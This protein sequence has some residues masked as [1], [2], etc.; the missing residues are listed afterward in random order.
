MYFYHLLIFLK[1]S[2]VRAAGL[3]LALVSFNGPPWTSFPGEGRAVGESR[4][5]REVGSA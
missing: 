1:P 4:Q 5:K 3:H 2:P